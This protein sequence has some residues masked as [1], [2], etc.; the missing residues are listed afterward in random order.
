MRGMIIAAILD[1]LLD[2]HLLDRSIFKQKHM[3]QEM[4][5]WVI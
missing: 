3:A 5:N 2:Q 1:G 4:Y